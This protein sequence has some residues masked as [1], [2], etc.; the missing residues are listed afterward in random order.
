MSS[1]S[2][3][4]LAS[5]SPLSP[6]EPQSVF[7]SDGKPHLQYSFPA[8]QQVLRLH[9]PPR[10]HPSTSYSTALINV[11]GNYSQNEI[12]QPDPCGDTSATNRL[13][14]AMFS[15]IASYPQPSFQYPTQHPLQDYPQ[16][17]ILQPDPCGDTSVTSRLPE[18][19]FSP[20]ASYP[21]PSF[22][23]PTQHPLQD[24]P[25][26]PHPSVPTNTS[27]TP[28]AGD[29]QRDP[30][31]VERTATRRLVYTTASPYPHHPP[32]KQ[33]RK[34]ENPERVRV[35]DEVYARTTIPSIKQQKELAVKLDM[36]LEEVQI[37]Y[38]SFLQ[39]RPCISCLR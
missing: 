6:V 33:R 8:P 7:L 13:P 32:P 24:M 19:I 9:P 38:I 11:S 26:D 20:V 37:W 3:S 31:S 28:S 25:L 34:R 2:T 1:S 17:E 4:V 27:T 18:A 5:R 16:N 15:P 14:E 21:Q 29:L 35:L 10:S 23:Y 22:Q 39:H 36:T 12:W 30:V